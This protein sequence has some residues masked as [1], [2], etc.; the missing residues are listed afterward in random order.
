MAGILNAGCAA[1]RVIESGSGDLIETGIEKDLARF[2]Q[3]EDS[4]R[5]KEEFAMSEKGKA[6]KR[7]EE[8]RTVKPEAPK[9]A[10]KRK[11][12]RINEEHEVTIKILSDEKNLPN[13]KAV[14]ERST[15]LSATG[16]KLHSKTH[17]PVDTLLN[18][19]LSLQ[20]LNQ[21][22]K[23]L[24]KV[25]W[26]KVIIEDESYEAGIEFVDTPKEAMKKIQDYINLKQ[27]Y[28][29]LNPVAVP[30]RIFAKFNKPKY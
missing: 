1:R 18:M 28:N 26:I 7:D 22:I 19:D 17:L 8:N 12:R 4:G 16:A 5:K 24:G 13:G 3:E 11:A 30:F 9:E 10:E 27:K 6:K 15:D 14:I 20:N 2:N 25:R 29:D 21:R 23:A